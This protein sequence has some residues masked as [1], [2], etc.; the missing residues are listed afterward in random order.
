MLGI[1]MIPTYNEAQ[2][3]VSLLETI[4]K[5]PLQDQDRLEVVVVDDNSPD[6]TAALV[7]ELQKKFP[8]RLHLIVRTQE[9]GRGTAGIRGFE[10]CLER[11]VDCI[12]EMDADFS[13]NPHYLPTFLALSRYYDLII[14]S[15]FVQDGID[16]HRSFSRMLISIIANAIYRL[17]LGLRIR[18]LSSGYKC[19][20]KELMQKLDFKKFLSQGY[21]IGMETVFYCHQLGARCLEIPIKFEDRRLG[22][23]KFSFKEIKEA[24]WVSFKLLLKRF[25]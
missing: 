22:S 11:N 3:I 25:S 14:G 13:H 15:R 2:N 8:D 1:V 18:D 19:Y 5:L 24:L 4:F 6:G 9:K 16:I 21:P 12:F 7:Q 23:S 17:C 20:R 10:F